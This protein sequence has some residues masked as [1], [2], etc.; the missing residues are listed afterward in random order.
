MKVEHT[1]MACHFILPIF[2][3]VETYG[4]YQ[5]GTNLPDQSSWAN[6]GNARSVGQ[7]KALTVA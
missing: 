6:S 5:C 7:I 1:Q 3:N 2:Q 4:R